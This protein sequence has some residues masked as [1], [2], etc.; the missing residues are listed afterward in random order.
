MLGDAKWGREDSQCKEDDRHKVS[1]T[2]FVQEEHFAHAASSST[3][4]V[5]SLF[6]IF[7]LYTWKDSFSSGIRQTNAMKVSKKICLFL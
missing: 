1:F 4:I 5:D 2:W 7:L 6:W 3:K